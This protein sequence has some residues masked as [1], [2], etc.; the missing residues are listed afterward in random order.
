MRPRDIGFAA[1]AQP[2]RGRVDAAT[3]FWNA[4]GV[5]LRAR[6]VRTREFRVDD[7]A[8]RA[9]PEVVLVVRRE[10]LAERR[11]DVEAA[12]RA[13]AAGT[14]AALADRDATVKEIA[15]ASEADEELVRSSRGRRAGD[16][17][18]ARPRPRGRGGLGRS[19]PTS[20]SSSA[21]PTSIGPSSLSLLS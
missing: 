11:A 4:E 10:T 6:G 21:R 9:Y 17:A 1:V 16:G 5:V 14:E 20:G 2:A 7:T 8:R 15:A 18:A 13:I 19:R 12:V 3:A